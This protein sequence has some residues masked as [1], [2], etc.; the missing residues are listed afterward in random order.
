M[1]YAGSD[2]IFAV[3]VDILME[4]NNQIMFIYIWMDRI[5]NGIVG[6]A[7]T[8]AKLSLMRKV[9]QRIRILKEEM[10]ELLANCV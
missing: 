7:L 1:G 9:L 8:I 5:F 6:L 2:F 4:C 3:D 10:S